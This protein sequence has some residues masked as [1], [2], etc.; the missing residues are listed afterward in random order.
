MVFANCPMFG[1]GGYGWGYINL[2]VGA[3]IFAVIFWGTYYLFMN[4]KKR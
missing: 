2:I 1:S 4:K 3:I